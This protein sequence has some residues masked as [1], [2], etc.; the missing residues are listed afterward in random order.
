MDNNVCGVVWYARARERAPDSLIWM[1]PEVL[2]GDPVDKK[3]DIYS[4]GIGT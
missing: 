4:F 3:S 1:S 2:R